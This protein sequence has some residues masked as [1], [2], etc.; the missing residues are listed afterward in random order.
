MV[1]G[2]ISRPIAQR[3]ITLSYDIVSEVPSSADKNLRLHRGR[4]IAGQPLSVE[5]RSGLALGR[6]QTYID[7]KVVSGFLLNKAA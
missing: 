2:F 6:N 1:I 7:L 5:Y 3:Q 4:G